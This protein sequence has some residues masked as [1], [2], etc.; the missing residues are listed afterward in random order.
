MNKNSDLV[1]STNPELNKTCPRCKKLLCACTCSKQKA[2]VD[3][4][5]IR[6]VLR[7]EKK[8]RGGKDV[9]IIERLPASEEFL[10][11]LSGNLKKKCGT[12]GTFKLID[13]NGVVE[14]QGDKHLQIKNEL[15]K[16]G[17]QCR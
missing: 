9:T 1:Y 5:T 7:L 8:H 4:S 17:I 15:E 10:A 13:G 11:E 14:I 6:A 3:T 2:S 12:G 16:M